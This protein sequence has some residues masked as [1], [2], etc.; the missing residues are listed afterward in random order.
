M[1]RR[2]GGT[3]W[4][5]L[6]SGAFVLL[7]LPVAG[8]GGAAD[9]VTDGAPPAQALPVTVHEVGATAKGAPILAGGTVRLRRETPLAFVRDGRVQS[10]QVR[11]GDVV[12]AGQLL[13]ALDRTPIDAEARAAAVQVRQAEAELARQ[14][15]LLKQGWVAPARVETAETG[16]EAARAA[17]SGARFA[18]R[19]AVIA[20]PSAGVVLQRLAE[21]GQTLAAGTPVLLLGEFAQ[22]FVLRVPLP[23]ARVEALRQGDSVAVRFRDGAAP[24]MMGRLIE[25]AGRADPATGTFQAEFALPAHP[26]LRSGLIAEV[27]LGGAGV[28]GRLQI[29]A[30]ALF[31]ARAGEGFVWRID[32]ASGKVTAQLVK[33]GA[34]TP[35]GVEVKGGL[36]RGDLIVAGGVNRLIEGQAVRPVE[37]KAAA[38]QAL[39]GAAA[40]PAAAG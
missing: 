34:V 28:P 36:A 1:D 33:L 21:P 6:V 8:C 29:P 13:A 22:G 2:N 35:A 14:R 3:G 15:T 20:A 9:E 11:E 10:V 24:P 5:L 31:A 7:V 32:G 27:E 18:Q 23:A 37:P 16:A 38:G 17:L 39:P 40:R 12:R 4:R 30:T 26:A 25:I 19:F